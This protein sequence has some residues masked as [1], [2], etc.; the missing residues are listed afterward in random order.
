VHLGLA[1]AAMV[2]CFKR[3]TEALRI[4]PK[5]AA[6]MWLA[7]QTPGIAQIEVARLL[8][9]DRA[10]ILGITNTLVRR[11][12]V[13]RGT[14]RKNGPSDARRIGLHLT[15]AGVDVLDRAR[16]AIALHEARFLERLTPE[17]VEQ[18]LLILRKLYL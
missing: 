17:E 6:L 11:R 9:V 12:L 5:Q 2:Q 14:A 3:E 8:R 13:M 7:E 1:H 18:G 4:T 16:A 15:P 10:T